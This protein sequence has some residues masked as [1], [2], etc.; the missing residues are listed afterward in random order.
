MAAPVGIVPQSPETAPGQKTN[1]CLLNSLRRIPFYSIP[2][3]E[4]LQKNK[5][6][7]LVDLFDFSGRPHGCLIQ[8]LLGSWLN[9]AEFEKNKEKYFQKKENLV[10]STESNAE[11]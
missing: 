5:R 2:T 11:K 4:D 8:L 9:I 6:P 3:L 1:R 7:T 10:D